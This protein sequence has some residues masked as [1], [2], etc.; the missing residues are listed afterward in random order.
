MP[1]A[2]GG[3]VQY[4]YGVF[5]GTGAT[6]GQ[7]GATAQTGGQPGGGS[8]NGGK[9]SI[10]G[11]TPSVAGRTSTGGA[12]F[13]TAYGVVSTVIAVTPAGGGGSG[14]AVTTGGID[15]GMP[16]GGVHIP[17]SIVAIYGAIFPSRF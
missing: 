11:G 1:L 3:A 17:V 9:S 14:G 13:K 6:I 15:T 2:T 8:A 4:F 12:Q 10:D 7:G 5:N 16:T